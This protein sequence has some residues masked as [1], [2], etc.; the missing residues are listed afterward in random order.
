MSNW[1]AFVPYVEAWRGAV[2][3]EIDR[4]RIAGQSISA[5][6]VVKRWDEGGYWKHSVMPRIEAAHIGTLPQEAFVSA[7]LTWASGQ[8]VAEIGLVP[9]N[10]DNFEA[11]LNEWQSDLI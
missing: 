1:R 5:D 11:Q 9:F 3:I 6:N 4:T 8:R 10:D 2:W 7:F